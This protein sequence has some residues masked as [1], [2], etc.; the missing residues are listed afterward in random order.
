M[1]EP[2]T[3]L[4]SSPAYTG[5]FLAMAHHKLGHD[6]EAEKWLVNATEWSDKVL[7]E[8]EEGTSTLPWNRRLTLKLLREEAEGLMIE[9]PVGEAVP[10]TIR[11]AT[12]GPLD[13]GKP[14][15]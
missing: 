12:D 11:K 5:Y 8:H 3:G 4:K 6:A 2:E 10:D 7:S 9:E 1:Q 14:E 13:G 15:G